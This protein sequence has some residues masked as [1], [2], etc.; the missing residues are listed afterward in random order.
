MYFDELFNNSNWS[1]LYENGELDVSNYTNY[2]EV[3]V[4]N[5]NK[6]WTTY[7]YD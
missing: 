2:T 6:S 4:E 1:A 7:T 3:L 5:V